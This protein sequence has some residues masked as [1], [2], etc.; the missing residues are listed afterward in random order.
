M[1]LYYVS[2]EIENNETIVSITKEDVAKEVLFLE[3][4]MAG[5]IVGPMSKVSESNYFLILLV[6][7]LLDLLIKRIWKPF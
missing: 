5:Y 4:A 6:G 7:M 2:H 3:I 1:K